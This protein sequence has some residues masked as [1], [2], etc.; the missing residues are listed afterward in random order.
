[1]FPT[2][3]KTKYVSTCLKKHT[4][5]MKCDLLEAC[6]C[7]RNTAGSYWALLAKVLADITD[8]QPESFGG[9]PNSL[10]IS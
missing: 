4:V 10:A 3:S 7:I 6:R 9:I 5:K 1:M 2:C 8:N